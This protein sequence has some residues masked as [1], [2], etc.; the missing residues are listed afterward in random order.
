MR[1]AL[2][3]L[4][5]IAAII[6]ASAAGAV[7]P[8]PD[9]VVKDR[10]VE[11]TVLLD[12]KI[13]ADPALAANCLAEG[14][15]WLRTN[16]AEAALA[17]AGDPQFFKDGR[18]AFERKYRIRSVVAGRYVSILRDDYMDT[19]GAHPNSNVDTVLWDKTAGKRI[20]I[21]P[22]FTETAANGPT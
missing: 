19:K 7:D 21:R 22:F 20:S 2:R 1:S 16:A 11:A 17:R 3:V 13:R 9:A 12:D 4:A 8:K 6:M 18:W 15:K 14:R 10:N 5:A